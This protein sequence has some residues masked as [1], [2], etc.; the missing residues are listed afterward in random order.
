MPPPLLR[1]VTSS[2]VFWGVLASG[3]V[4][5]LALAAA[6]FGQSTWA[7]PRMYVLDSGFTEGT[8]APASQV[9]EKTV[10]M[11]LGAR[12]W[13]DGTPSASLEDRLAA[14]LSLYRAKKVS[15]ILVTGD[16]GQSSYNEVAVMHRWLVAQGV[17]S[18]AIFADHAGFRTH[19][20]MQRAAKVFEVTKA[21]VCT[22]EFH[23]PRALFLAHAAGI[24][25]V[26]VT[27]NRRWYRARWKNK[28]REAMARLVAVGD[29]WVWGREP[30]YLG[31]KIPI[32]GDA[33]ASHD[34]SI[35]GTP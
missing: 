9:P 16:N 15:R 7:G 10:A 28:V 13:A 25:A 26:G 24:D 21:I 4:L 12:V 32:T 3:A 14:A 6:N 8:Y 11:V 17:P 23:L 31:Q 34:Q 27:A 29:V 33:R 2:W 30:R 22:Q 20:S 35:L 5:L 1:R 18:T 19:D